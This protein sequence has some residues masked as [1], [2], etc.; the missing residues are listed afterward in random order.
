[1]ETTAITS[2]V[3]AASRF[4]PV[5]RWPGGKTRLLKSLLP[6]PGHHCYV[7]PFA[8]GLA[9]LLAKERS[10]IEVVNDLNGD[11]V[12]LYR[13]A[14]FH[15][16]ALIQELALTLNSRRNLKDFMAQPGLTDLQRAARFLMRNKTSFGGGMESYGVSKSG[17]GA[18]VSRENIAEALRRLNK[19]LD[20]VSV[21][22]LPYER[23]LRLYDGPETLFFLDPPYLNA[24]IKTYAGWNEEQMTAFAQHVGS[25]QGNWIVTVDD[26]EVNRRLFSA[27]HIE[28]VVTANGATNQRTHPKRQFGELIIRKA[29]AES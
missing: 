22:N 20:M 23:V 27:W 8:G 9:V 21:E 19:R 15:H 11:L 18:C 26:S 6:L 3:V 4:K 17:G 25:L 24:Q 29:P 5:V 14:Q 2:H 1:M 13:C 12:T 10:R 7:E 28:A 16:E